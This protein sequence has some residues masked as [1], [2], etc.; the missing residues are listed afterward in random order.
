MAATITYI[1]HL[2][3]RFFIWR[4]KKLKKSKMLATDGSGMLLLLTLLLVV[5]VVI[6]CYIEAVATNCKLNHQRLSVCF[7]S[8]AFLLTHHGSDHQPTGRTLNR[9]R[10]VLRY[11]A[12][13]PGRKQ[14]GKDNVLILSCCH[15]PSCITLGLYWS[16]AASD[17]FCRLAVGLSPGS[18]CR[19]QL[20]SK[21]VSGLGRCLQSLIAREAIRSNKYTWNHLGVLNNRTS[22][23]NSAADSVLCFL[24]LAIKCHPSGPSHWKCVLRAK[25]MTPSSPPKPVKPIALNLLDHTRCFM[26]KLPLMLCWR[27]TAKSE[28][29]A[30]AKDSEDTAV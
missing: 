1:R 29:T 26:D 5:V 2:D 6:Y 13:F 24:R 27:V 30:S 23:R 18:K 21:A 9:Q 20:A 14:L 8:P 3:V 10:L 25:A 11:R 7:R 17:I 16:S 28:P 4:P 12:F 15:K 19:Q 22:W